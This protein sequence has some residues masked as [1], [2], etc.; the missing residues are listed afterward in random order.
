MLGR[1]VWIAKATRAALTVLL[2]IGVVVWV[3]GCF[4]APNAPPV[5]VIT[6]D[7]IEGHA[8]LTVQLSGEASHDPDGTVVSYRWELPDGAAGT[9]SCLAH[10][11]DAPGAYS[12]T[13]TLTDDDGAC[14]A[15]SIEIVV[16]EANE[17]PTA[18]FSIAPSAALPGEE[19][20]VDGTLSTDSDGRVVTYTWS[21][22][23]G[24]SGTGPTAGHRYEETG[25]YTIEL[26]VTD[27]DGARATRA[28]QVW[29]VDTNRPPIP[30]LSVST[31]AA[32]PGEEIH[33]DASESYDPD[34]EIT[35]IGWS[36]GDGVTDEGTHVSHRYGEAGTYRVTLSVRDDRGSLQSDSIELVIGT[37]VPGDPASTVTRTYRWSYGGRT[38]TLELTISSETYE[39]YAAQPRDEWS[40]R[41]YAE[42]VLDP[43]DDLYLEDVAA[44]VAG[45]VA[46]EYYATVENAL[47]FVQ[48]C[49]GYAPDPGP[50]DYPRYPVETLYDRVGD[51]E[52]TAILYTSLIRTLG[53]GALLAL[54]D[55]DNDG[56][57]DHMVAYV[58]VEEAYAAARPSGSF[59]EYEGQ[60]YAFAETAVEGGYVPL[61][62][63]PWG[64]GADD[65]D[66]VYNVSRVDVS[67][68]MVKRTF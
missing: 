30:V 64:V 27:D 38:R 45:A 18:D 28:R 17:T 53:H 40:Q 25:E 65:I 33:F 43:L 49:I 10:V 3:A 61:G 47:A 21:F 54:V 32:E 11:F 52:D 12:V 8:P 29:I 20:R 46:G 41:D 59:W 34:G 9:E 35:A 58:P 36:F 4:L 16:G 42:Y 7:R 39:Y 60:L 15:T 66:R 6:A 23:D 26:E 37:E 51:C 48:R 14:S 1:A 22:G 68:H 55:T 62:T 50:F 44:Q 57:S 13:L 63:D 56:R 5:A 31:R 19:V 24:S 67:P 2:A